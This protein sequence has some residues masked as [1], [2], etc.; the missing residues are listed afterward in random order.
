MTDDDHIAAR[1]ICEQAPALNLPPADTRPGTAAGTRTTEDNAPN[2]GD[3]PGEAMAGNGP[4]AQRGP[5]DSRLPPP[6]ASGSSMFQS[7]A[8]AVI[9][10]QA[11]EAN[12]ICSSHVVADLALHTVM[13]QENT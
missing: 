8:G 12:P 7:R 5:D 2:A 3:V 6:N 9:R 4:E 11:A 10:D 1:D 13:P